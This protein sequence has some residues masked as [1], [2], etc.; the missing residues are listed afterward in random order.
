VPVFLIMVGWKKKT[1]LM[2][3]NS[4]IRLHVDTDSLSDRLLNPDEYEPLI[5]AVNQQS[6]H[7]KLPK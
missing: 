2:E 5:T 6:M 3:A 7:R 4:K 1:S